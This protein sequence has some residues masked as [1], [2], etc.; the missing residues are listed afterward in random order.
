QVNT[1]QGGD[2]GDLT[3]IQGLRRQVFG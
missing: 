2:W 1:M 3:V